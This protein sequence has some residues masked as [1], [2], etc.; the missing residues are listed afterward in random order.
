MV[1]RFIDNGGAVHEK[2]ITPP[3]VL[4]LV[5]SLTELHFDLGLGE[6]IVGRTNFCIHPATGVADIPSVGGTKKINFDKVTA[7]NPSHV[8]V[9]IDETPKELAEKLASI[10]I[11]VIVTHPIVAR[12]NC[13]LFQLIGGLFGAVDRAAELTKKFSDAIAALTE[14]S[15]A[16]DRQNALY[17]IWQDPWMS[18][19]PNTYIADVLRQAN[20]HT[21]RHPN[22]GRYP[23]ICL[24][25]HILQEVDLV[26]FS[27]EPF[28]FNQKHLK[29]FQKDFPAHADKARLI[30]AEMVSWYGS[31]SINGLRYLAKFAAR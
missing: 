27:S 3:T 28:P 18:I 11:E 22:K 2:I 24:D 20:W 14:K 8:L 4:S 13:E 5:P 31:R 30:D 10:G 12:D 1:E 6:Q 19:S 26:L 17:L 9:N 21:P 15:Q 29:Q 7:L 25:T 23:A 16:W